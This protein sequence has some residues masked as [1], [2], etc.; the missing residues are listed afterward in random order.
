MENLENMTVPKPKRR[1]REIFAVVL[2]VLIAVLV[3][4]VK[5]HMNNKAAKE[6]ALL[7]ELQNVRT[8][9]ELYIT[10]NKTLPADMKALV[11]QKYTMG[12][13]NGNYLTGA[14]IGKNGLP[15]DPFGNDFVYNPST[16]KVT[17]GTKGYEGW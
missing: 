12:E 13:K 2:I 14:K 9:V 4:G 11:D 1:K 15:V 10:L 7:A 16:G 3:L 17:S 5:F 6:A 8:S